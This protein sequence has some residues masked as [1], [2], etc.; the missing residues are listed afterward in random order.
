MITHCITR[1]LI[2]QR[3]HLLF[4]ATLCWHT[5]ISF[6]LKFYQKVYHHNKKDISITN[7][8]RNPKNICYILMLLLMIFIS[9]IYKLE[10]FLYTHHTYQNKVYII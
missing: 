2:I 5:I 8:Y 9:S 6:K 4:C 1:T 10:S 3:Y 7:F